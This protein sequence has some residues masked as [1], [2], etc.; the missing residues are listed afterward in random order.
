[1]TCYFQPLIN[2]RGCFC[3]GSPVCISLLR[4]HHSFHSFLRHQMRW[5]DSITNSV[6]MNLSKLWEVVGDREAWCAAVH[7]FAKSWTQLCIW[8]TTIQ[9]LS[10]KLGYRY[11][12]LVSF[13]YHHRGGAGGETD[14]P[15][16]SL[17]ASSMSLFSAFI[18]L[19][20]ISP[21]TSPW[22]LDLL[23]SPSL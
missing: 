10:L 19:Q 17:P 11:F 16:Y 6:D 1:M 23:F 7:G 21:L 3:M 9:T 15:P 8:T 22:K 5:L 4:F 18:I 20:R 13:L 12:H 14:L 2:F